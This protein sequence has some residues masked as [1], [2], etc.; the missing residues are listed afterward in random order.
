MQVITIGRGHF[1]KVYRLSCLTEPF[2]PHFDNNKPPQNN[3]RIVSL[4]INVI[5]VDFMIIL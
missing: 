3:F 4:L 1:R 5:I 2:K